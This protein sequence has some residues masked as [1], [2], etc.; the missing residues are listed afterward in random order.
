MANMFG[1]TPVTDYT[2]QADL[3]FKMSQDTATKTKKAMQN[4]SGIVIEKRIAKQYPDAPYGEEALKARVQAY[5]GIDPERSEQA[6]KMLES[7]YD[8]SVQQSKV[9]LDKTKFG[10]NVAKDERDFSYTAQKDTDKR[11]FDREKEGRLGREFEQEQEIKREQLLNESEKIGIKESE[12]SAAEADRRRQ[13]A[14]EKVTADLNQAK[15]L[16]A[17]RAKGVEEGYTEQRLNFEQKKL[18]SDI[19]NGSLVYDTGTGQW[20]DKRTRKVIDIEG[21]ASARTQTETRPTTGIDYIE[22]KDNALLNRNDAD[23]LIA[24]ATGASQSKLAKAQ[25]NTAERNY[26]E[27]QARLTKIDNLYE[28]IKAELEPSLDTVAS[29]RSQLEEIKNSD[30]PRTLVTNIT[31]LIGRLNQDKRLSNLD[32]TTALGTGSI[33]EQL[34]KG[35]TQLISG[36]LDPDT[37]ASMED[38]F[39]FMEKDTKRAIRTKEW[40]IIRRDLNSSSYVKEISS[41]PNVPFTDEQLQKYNNGY[42]SLLEDTPSNKA[43]LDLDYYIHSGLIPPTR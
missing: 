23:N 9:S 36:K 20:F 31:K 40:N 18:E 10:Y 42:F 28:P 30:N 7:A 39:D 12:L 1:F 15:F 25:Q 27:T 4:I 33:I 37:L 13:S 3:G 19:A 8:R 38:L 35:F 14:K 41:L 43:N 17:V 21:N 11:A 5:A 22:A 34:N 24:T 6:K 26:K 32:F 2:R 29:G 16:E